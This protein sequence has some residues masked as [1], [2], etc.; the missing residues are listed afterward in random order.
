MS[1]ENFTQEKQATSSTNKGLLVLNIVLLIS[2]GVLYILFFTNNNSDRTAGISNSEITASNTEVSYG[3]LKIAYVN[4][5]SIMVHYKLAAELEKEIVS[6]RNNLENSYTN[7]VQKL[8]SDVQEYLK[9]G[10]TLTLTEQRN[11]EESFKRRELEIGELQERMIGQIQEKQI[12]ENIRLLNAV[13]A[14]IRDYNQK[15]QQF[16]IILKKSFADSPVMYI[17][18]NMDITQD[19][20]D[21]LNKEYDELQKK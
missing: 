15:N 1:E 5:D 6:F 7:K 16:N 20:I 18:E 12:N 11:R 10:A 19:I 21:G 14:F 13:F 4:T 2:I 9:I 8:Q 17:D 3:D